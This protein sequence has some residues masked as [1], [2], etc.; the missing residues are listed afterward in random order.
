MASIERKSHQDLAADVR[1]KSDET[2]AIVENLK[3]KLSNTQDGL[4]C[5]DLKN[6]LMVDYMT[7]LTYLMLRKSFGKR[8]EGDPSIERMVENRTVLEKL[9]PIEKKL[10]YQVRKKIQIE[11]KK[12][13][14]FYNHG[15]Q[16]KQPGWSQKNWTLKH[17]D[18]VRK[19]VF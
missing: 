4:S 5:L 9:R 7:N 13:V 10:K 8:I 19:T 12:K 17:S 3:S 18:F 1:Q 2:V 6:L 11:D 14:Y 15:Q 16:T